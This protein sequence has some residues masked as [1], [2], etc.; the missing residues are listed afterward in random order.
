[1]CIQE[2]SFI[3]SGMVRLLKNEL[4]LFRFIG[5]FF[6]P[7]VVHFNYIC[8]LIALSVYIDWAAYPLIDKTLHSAESQNSLL[9][10]FSLPVPDLRYN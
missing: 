4:T 8:S 9:H 1:M 5:V 7:Q 3:A 2:S 6:P 10:V